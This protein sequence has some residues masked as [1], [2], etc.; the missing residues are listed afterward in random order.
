M[1]KPN[2][3]LSGMLVMLCLSGAAQM[4]LTPQKT[5]STLIIDGRL[6]E[7]EWQTAEVIEELIQGYPNIGAPPTERTQIRILYNDSYLY[8][9]IEANDSIPARIIATGLERDVYYSSDDHVSLMIDS[10]NDKRQA[11][12]FATNPLS[13]RFDEEV[14]DNG[15]AF[16][17]AFNTFWD[18]R[19]VRNEHGFSV[20]FQIPFSSLRFQATS[21]VTMG[22]K[23]VR[24]IKHRNEYDVFPTADVELANAVWRVNN[25]Q[26]IVFHELKAR[27]PFYFIPYI[28]GSYQE[29][30]SWNTT[31]SRTVIS[32]ELMHRNNFLK[33]EGADKFISNIGFDIKYGISKNFTLDATVNTDFAQA[34][35][36]NR[37]FN[38]TR[39]AINLP[40]KR[41][42]FLESRDYLS[43][44]TGSGM[45]LFNSRTI[46][47]EKGNVV[48]IIGGIRI[49]GKSNGLQVGLLDLQTHGV[50]VAG[51]DPQHFSVL[52]IRK[53]VWGNGSFIGG[54][55]TNRISTSGNS[56]NNQTIGVDAIKRFKDNKWMVGVN[57]ATTNDR[58]SNRFFSQSNMANLV[59]NRTVSVGYNLTSSFEYVEKSFKPASGFAPDSAYML[60]AVTN[61]YMWKGKETSKLNF[62][63]LTNSIQHKY[64]TIN[65]THESL[66]AELEWG[67]MFR[68]GATILLVPLGGR[69][70]L[71]YDW[72]FSGDIIIPANYYSYAGLKIQFGSRQ[73]KPINYTLTGTI[74]GF[75][76]GFRVNLGANGYYAINKNFRISYK[77]DFNDFHFPRHNSATGNSDFRSNLVS[78]GI[79]FTQSIYFSAKALVQ[80]DDISKTVGGNFRIRINPKEG[81]DLYIVYNPRLNT[82][83]PPNERVTIDQQTIIVKFT[84]AFG[85]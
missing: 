71:P 5:A 63:W 12:L 78:V 18:V 41:N 57:L 44:S 74:N 52:R 64:R 82:I 59:I 26:A 80:Y 56:F 58:Q 1:V 73:T 65:Q 28:K 8:V 38:F 2:T 84:T 17:A 19:S 53:E 55:V 20:E 77:Y 39:F 16:N 49:S 29:S 50:N 61:N 46:G 62:Y 76:G 81:T 42:F 60:S 15:N 24:Y 47:I 51:I 43:F 31:E 21:S 3:T 54:I 70:Y 11:L 9:G 32:N 72:N 13:A 85:L 83:F 14:L 6:D 75:F 22:I 40:E 48:P 7:A 33:D 69:E 66:Y 68:S 30:K 10:Y 27:K 36:D 35:T 4:P 45:L 34:E 79:A 37:I 25:C 23:V 67:N